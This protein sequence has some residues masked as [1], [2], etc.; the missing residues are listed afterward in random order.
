MTR[1]TALPLDQA[2]AA[3]RTALQGVE[4]GLGFIPNAE[5]LPV[6]ALFFRKLEAHSLST[7]LI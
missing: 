2:P 6:I 3:A 7:L 4:K 5:S 1:I